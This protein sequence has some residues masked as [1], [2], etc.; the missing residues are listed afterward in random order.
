MIK[1]NLKINQTIKGDVL[2]FVGPFESEEKALDHIE[3]FFKNNPF[4]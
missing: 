4:I 1:E 2:V 3:R